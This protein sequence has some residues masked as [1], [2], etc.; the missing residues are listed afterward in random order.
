MLISLLV[1]SNPFT[2]LG[3]MNERCQFNLDVYKVKGVSK[4]PLL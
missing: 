2:A 3:S 1:K 4:A